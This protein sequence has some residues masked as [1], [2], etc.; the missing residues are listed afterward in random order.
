MTMD[1]NKQIVEL[2]RQLIGILM[3]YSNPSFAKEAVFKLNQKGLKPE[4]FSYTPHQKVYQAILA[5]VLDDAPVNAIELLEWLKR[6]KETKDI[7]LYTDLLFDVGSKSYNP[8]DLL[9]LVTAIKDSFF[10]RKINQ[11]ASM[12]NDISCQPAL[13]TDYA[14]AECQN[15]IGLLIKETAQTMGDEDDLGKVM[16]NYL[17]ELL[18]NKETPVYDTG[19]FD[20]DE[21]VHFVPKTLNILAGRPSMGKTAMALFL[22]FVISMRHQKPCYIFSLEMAKEQLVER[23]FTMASHYDGWQEYGLTQVDSWR[24][25]QHKLSKLPS[26][27]NDPDAQPLSEGEINNLY[28]IN[29]IFNHHQ[30]ENS[31]IGICDDR[32]VTPTQIEI[33]CREFMRKKKVDSLGLVVVDYVQE[34]A[35]G[36]SNNSA[37]RSN[38]IGSI[39][40]QL[41]DVSSRINSPILLLAQLKRGVEERNDKR[42]NMSDLADSGA[43]EQSADTIMMMYRDGYYNP[44]SPEKHLAELLVKKNRVTGA[45]GT[46]KFL[47]RPH[48][49]VFKNLSHERT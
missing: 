44:E 3:G 39:C 12:L 36:T 13:D 7:A 6:Q 15:A 14:I 33:K 38:E 18:S 27:Q 24:L 17:T 30:S 35:K 23:F 1:A 5:V 25:N 45:I 26:K 40:R 10:R 49:C 47:F 8:H 43:I 9:S 46:A 20:F 16:E 22:L 32:M 11:V 28:V 34:M 4:W 37:E 42:P 48:E 2:E 21:I 31:L 19:L 41:R 29:E